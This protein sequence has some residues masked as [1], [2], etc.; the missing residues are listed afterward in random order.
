MILK[1]V[2]KEAKQIIFVISRH[3]CLTLLQIL[4]LLIRAMIHGNDKLSITQ[5]TMGM[6]RGI[7]AHTIKESNSGVYL[8]L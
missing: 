5:R 1:L 8:R 3:A 4:K 7:C 2:T 6:F